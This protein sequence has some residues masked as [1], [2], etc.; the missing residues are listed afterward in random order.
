MRYILFV[1]MYFSSL[2]L[3]AQELWLGA[4]YGDSAE[5]ILELFPNYETYAKEDELRKIGSTSLT[6]L[7]GVPVELAKRP[8]VAG[9]YF[10]SSGLFQIIIK[11]K[12]LLNDADANATES[13][14]SE[15]LVKKYGYAIKTADPA[16]VAMENEPSWAVWEK[17]GLSIM[18]RRQHD[19]TP[20]MISYELTQA[21]Q[22]RL[23]KAAAKKYL[24]GTSVSQ[25][26]DKL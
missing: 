2:S 20:T 1:L 25:E 22:E 17:D 3:N 4:M 13:L 16:K 26:A 7:I 8:F 6:A 15:A 10:N 9:F 11:N 21:E 23:E 5:K 18:L 14:L 12:S 19:K 24:E